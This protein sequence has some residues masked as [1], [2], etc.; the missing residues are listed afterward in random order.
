M[1]SGHW[2][3]CLGTTI[4]GKTLGLLGFGRLGT[5]VAAV[6]A[7]FGMQV[8]AWS[9]NLNEEA[10]R[11]GGARYVS[12]EALF[13]QSDFVSVH[14][15][16]GDRSRGLVA[17]PELSLMKP[18]AYL[19]NT[20]R[21]PIVDEASLIHALRAKSIA[22]AALDVFDTEPL[23]EHHELRTFDNALLTPHLGYVTEESMKSFYS[24]SVENIRAFLSRA[25][26]V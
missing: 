24:A 13:A 22:G 7:A 15:V 23:P 10:A 17:Q 14:L 2:Q 19:I 25:S 12:K 1:R 20:S 16:L 9:P 18:S 3:T 6:A 8:I 26:H 4:H 21:G 5:R 11:A